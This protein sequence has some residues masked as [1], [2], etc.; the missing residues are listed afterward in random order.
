VTHFIGSG[1]VNRALRYWARSHPE[2]ARRAKQRHPDATGFKLSDYGLVPI[3]RKPAVR[4]GAGY[5]NE[6]DELGP[7]LETRTETDIWQ[8]LGLAYVPP[9]MRFFGPDYE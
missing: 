8:A 9:H 6:E 7:P 1:S 5:K 2:A 3:K 4:S